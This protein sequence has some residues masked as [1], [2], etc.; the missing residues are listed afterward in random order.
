MDLEPG[1]LRHTDELRSAGFTVA[2]L[3]RMRH[4]G[5]LSRLRRGSYVVGPCPDDPALRHGLLVRATAQRLSDQA[6]VS[7]VSAAVLHGLPVWG[8]PLGRVH[9]T[10]GRRSGA[11]SSDRVCVHTAPVGRDEVTAI[12]GITVTGLARTVVDVARRVPFEQAVV[13][14]DAALRTGL[15]HDELDG[16]LAR[17][18]GWQGV[19]T[20]RRAVRFADGRSES[21][22]ESRSRVAIARAGLP[23]PVLQWEIRTARG[24]R[25]TDFGWPDL[26]TVGEFDGRVKYGRLLRPG[27]DAG[28]AVFAEKLREDEVRDEDIAMVRWTWA[29]LA[30]FDAVADRLRRRFRTG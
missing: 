25:R 10:R 30:Q 14:A 11:R 18:A 5:T 22:G 3:G 23:A 8:L 12:D 28:D 16:A 9:A 19:P 4:D 27:Q 26:R 20:A 2:E 15:A 1:A 17:A 21:V 6:V 24:V 7:H 29:D 13:V